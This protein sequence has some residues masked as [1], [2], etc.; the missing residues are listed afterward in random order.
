MPEESYASSPSSG[1]FR[2]GAPLPLSLA[3]FFLL[4]CVNS[5]VAKFVVFTFQLAPGVSSF[6]IVVACMIV[7]TLWFGLWGAGAA[8][9]GCFIGA[10]LLSDIPAGVALYWSLADLWEVLIPFVVFRVMHADPGIATWRDLIILIVSGCLLNNIV[11]AVWGASTLALG[12]EIPGDALVSTM[13]GWMLVNWIVCLIIV[14][15]VLYLI[16]P[17]IREHELFVT[18]YWN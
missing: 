2:A 9:I 12:G 6:Y 10:G 3:L 1:T 16:T 8:Y 15:P 18:R 17:Y 4:I 14:P 11:G 5:L 13:A 7:F